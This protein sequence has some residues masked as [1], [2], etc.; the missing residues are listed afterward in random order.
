MSFLLKL[1]FFKYKPA[2]H[3]I[4]AVYTS[5]CKG[6]KD[7][8]INAYGNNY[9]YYYYDGTVKS[10]NNEL[11]KY[12]NDKLQNNKKY[13]FNAIRE[14]SN[15]IGVINYDTVLI[16]RGIGDIGY[17]KNEKINDDKKL[18]LIDIP[19]IYKEDILNLY[20]IDLYKKI[21]IN[22]NK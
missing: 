18:L 8:I 5:L 2:P 6:S 10:F 11:T 13:Y 14:T 12:E 16:R 22:Y 9:K 19:S 15:N 21:G 1:S 7:E 4:N 20:F 17:I 3:V